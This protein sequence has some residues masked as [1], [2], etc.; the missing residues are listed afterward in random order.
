MSSSLQDTSC[1]RCLR[2]D[3]V[4]KVS[5][6]TQ[7]GT[8]PTLLSQQLAR[9]PVPRLQSPWGWKSVLV[10]FSGFALGIASLRY[11]AFFFIGL[12]D[13]S[14]N[15]LYIPPRQWTST[16]EAMT[17]TIVTLGVAVAILVLKARLAKA[18]HN[19]YDSELSRWRR[20]NTQWQDL[21]YCSRD[22][23][24]FLHGTAEVYPPSDMRKLLYGT[25]TA[26]SQPE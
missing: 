1:P 9:P 6:L 26:L 22:G 3:C 19:L 14:V 23:V 18:R 21:Y 7:A 11:S 25:K 24:I 10:L 15:N 2:A 17:L 8:C 4:Q 16:L 12:L 5:A 20:G 13:A